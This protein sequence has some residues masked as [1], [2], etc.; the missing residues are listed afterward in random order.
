MANH[1]VSHTKQEM[2]WERAGN[3]SHWFSEESEKF[4]NY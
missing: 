1:N 3:F 4:I 2:V